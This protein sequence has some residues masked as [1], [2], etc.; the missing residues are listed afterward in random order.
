M[1]G[2][3]FT[4]P[5]K[6]RKS[7]GTKVTFVDKNGDLVTGSTIIVDD[8]D[9]FKDTNGNEILEWSVTASAVNHIGIVNSATGNNPI[10]R[11]EGEADTGITFDNSESEEIL[12]IDGVATAVNEITITNAAT[13]NN[14]LIS[15]TGEADTGITFM[16]DQSEEILILDAIATAVNELTI[17]NAATGNKPIIA[18]TG[19]ADTGIEFHNDQSEEILILASAATS[20]N[21]VT[22][23]SAATGTTG[24]T[25]AAT[26]E[27][28]VNLKLLAAGTGVVDATTDGIGTK[29][30]VTNIT[31]DTPSDAELVTAL[32]AV[33][34]S[35]R[36][37]IG[38]VDDND[39]DTGMYLAISS[40]ATWYYLRLNKAL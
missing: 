18:A 17:K 39:A 33:A 35:G 29:Q 12:I 8:G 38:T 1:A 27:T 36:G 2:S 24:P 31:D 19:E 6:I 11:A 25:I 26:G 28:N 14:P 9:T 15:A 34:A 40:D 20:V 7:D 23:T 22:I 30:A 37:F 32:G 13:G 21:E 16:N 4:G 5:L 10:I 3:S